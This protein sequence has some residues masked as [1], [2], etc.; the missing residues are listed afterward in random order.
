MSLTSGQ[1]VL[2]QFAKEIYGRYQYLGKN[3]EVTKDV[4]HVKHNNTV[5]KY[6]GTSGSVNSFHL[7]LRR[8]QPVGSNA[9]RCQHLCRKP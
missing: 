2:V 1:V 9:S 8:H 7:Q 3:V 4:T 5:Y 6:L